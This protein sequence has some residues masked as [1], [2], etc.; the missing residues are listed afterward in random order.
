MQ[1]STDIIQLLFLC[2]L[3]RHKISNTSNSC[4]YDWLSLHMCLDQSNCVRFQ[5][6]LR[7]NVAR[8]T[9]LIS[10]HILAKEFKH[11]ATISY[12]YSPVW[13]SCLFFP[14]VVCFNCRIFSQ[15]IPEHWD[16]PI[17]SIET[18]FLEKEHFTYFSTMHNT[19]CFLIL[20]VLIMF[21]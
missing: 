11:Q 7:L 2:S 14:D 5:I 8:L 20:L 3:S 6:S 16:I 10:I 9:I 21:C 18:A 1:F 15:S 12:Y 17:E 4:K 13:L 19:A